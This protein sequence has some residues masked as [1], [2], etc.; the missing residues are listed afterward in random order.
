MKPVLFGL[1]SA[2]A[3]T[4]ATGAYAQTETSSALEDIITVNGETL[5][6]HTN[7]APDALP[8]MGNDV[9]A[10]IARTP[11][12]ARI[13]NGDLSG[14][15]QY[16]GLF[17]ERLNLRVDGQRF[18][19]GGPNLMDPV[20]HY[21]PE[22]LV[23]TIIIDRGV[24][25][26]SEGP[27][28][29]GGADAR[30]KRVDF[31]DKTDASLG[32]DVSI[33]GRSVN[34]SYSVGGVMG[35]ST[36][37]WR[38]NLLGSYEHG[39]DT[40]IPDGFIGGSEFERQVYGLSAGINTDIGTFSLDG[41][42]QN[43]GAS[44]NP[45]FPMDIRFFDTDFLRLAYDTNIDG[46]DIHASVSS[47]DVSHAMNNFDLRASPVMM[48]LR[49]TYADATTQAAELNIRFP[50]F[51][52]T[53]S[54]GTDFEN[55]EHNARITN[56]VNANFYVTP[57]PNIDMSSLGG[58]AQ[59]DG[60]VSGLNAELGI[61]VDSHAYSASDAQVGP[62]LPMMPNM[63]A[64]AFNS[65]DKDGTDTTVDIVARGWTTAKNGLSWR[66]TLARKQNMPGY[67][68]RYGWLPINASGG[69]ADGNI[70]VGDLNLKP[71]T[72]LI[73]EAGAD[74]FGTKL[75]AR[76]TVFIRNIDNYIQGIAFDDT[77]GLVNSPVE[78]I[79]RM[80][81]DE[82][83]LKWANVDARLYGVD[84]DFGYDFDGPLRLD[85]VLSYVR[86]ERRDIDDNLYRVAPPSL[87]SQLTWEGSDWSLSGEVKLVAKQDNVS[88]TNSETPSDSYGLV[89]LYAQ[90]Q[91]TDEVSLMVGVENLLNETYRDH[92]SG[93]NR[94]GYGDVPIGER[95]PGAGRGAFIRLRMTR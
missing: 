52:G 64:N 49:E 18:A 44:G 55:T 91:I 6:T 22:S 63:L 65:A 36:K 5:N 31:T 35:A 11:G 41:R 40:N 73:A 83:P 62:A 89:N 32:Y 94:N 37:R 39:D 48:R 75:Y 80:N 10:L 24:S 82:T 25:P 16:R 79:A 3:L 13:G 7:I 45:A 67:I 90:K 50:T 69:L 53:L 61:R 26:V 95:V 12:A 60:A 84:M 28:L 70:Y 88:V 14:Q 85:N 87:T 72:A 29:A 42:R 74:Y 93:V 9:T 27:G 19:S 78:M 1:S 17:G 43:T 68:Q 66:G 46:I 47:M 34:E 23:S 38:F 51:G 54:L 8:L 86:G 58:F 30:F 33:G 56:P 92:L 59:W 76:P 4:L 77:P 2:L 21:A 20:F 71:E 57:F 81:G 15:M